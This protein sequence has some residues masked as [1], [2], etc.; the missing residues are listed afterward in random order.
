[1]YFSKFIRSSIANKILMKDRVRE[2]ILPDF[3]T[4]VKLHCGMCWD[5]NSRS[6][7]LTESSEIVWTIDLQ[8]EKGT[9]VEKG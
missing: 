8:N 3:M 6:R 9:S 4:I 2:L 7:N 5:T 1:M